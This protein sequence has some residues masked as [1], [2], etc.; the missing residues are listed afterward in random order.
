[1]VNLEDNAYYLITPNRKILILIHNNNNNDGINICDVTE[2]YNI[3]LKNSKFIEVNIIMDKEY[4]NIFTCCKYKIYKIT[5]DNNC[6]LYKNL[7][8]LKCDNTCC[9]NKNKLRH[10]SL[11]NI[12]YYIYIYLSQYYITK[13]YKFYSDMITIN[14]NNITDYMNLKIIS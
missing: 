14:T 7:P 10:M 9:I 2:H 5:K 8:I 11:F 12:P 1:M 13:L 6:I 4:K 3:L